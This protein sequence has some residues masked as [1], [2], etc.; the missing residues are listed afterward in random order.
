VDGVGH[1]KNFERCSNC[2]V[3]L[4]P[5]TARCPNCGAPVFHKKAE[6][7]GLRR[8]LSWRYLRHFLIA[9]ILLLLPYIPHGLHWLRLKLPLRTSP[10]V[11]EAVSRVNDHAQAVE[12]LG[13]PITAGWFVKG[14]IRGDETGWS[15]G[16]V[17]IPVSGTKGEG[18]LYA[19]A[20]Q[21]YGPWVFSELRLTENNGRVVDLLAEPTPSSVAPLRTQSRVFIVPIGGVRG[22]G[23]HEL[24]EFYH[25]RLGL[26]VQLLAP[27]PLEARARNPARRQLIFEELVT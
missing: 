19:R 9:G 15:E 6:I 12:I 16:Q 22:L 20:G 23:L 24:P 4:A 5:A 2:N 13:Q 8:I 26:Q 25:R 17:W 14:Y 11:F 7:S 18:T 10:L 1:S 21:S 3:E 27:V